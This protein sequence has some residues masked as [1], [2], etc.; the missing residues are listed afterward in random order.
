MGISRWGLLGFLILAAPLPAAAQSDDTSS[1][2]ATA[3]DYIEGWYTGDAAR[4]SRALHPELVKRIHQHDSTT[5]RWWISNQGATN[6]VLGTARGGGTKTPT[7]KRRTEVKVLDVFRNAASVRVDADAW[8][9]YLQLVREGD[10]W[11]IVN[12]L[13][14]LRGP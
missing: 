8:V 12:V 6:L 3:K 11:L 2:V 4:M 14:E 7:E 9:D 10:R 1:I 5:G 13:W